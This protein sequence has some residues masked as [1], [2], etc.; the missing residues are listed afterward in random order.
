MAN[1]IKNLKTTR[2]YDIDHIEYLMKRGFVSRKNGRK[3][4]D[5]MYKQTVSYDVEESRKK[6]IEDQKKRDR[7]YRRVR[8]SPET[9]SKSELKQAVEFFNANPHEF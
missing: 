7:L 1:Y 8:E 5:K 2:D 9:L 6:L 4:I 3:L